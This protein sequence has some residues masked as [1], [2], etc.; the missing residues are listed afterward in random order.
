MIPCQWVL[1]Y[2]VSPAEDYDP[3]QKK[4]VSPKY[5]TKLHLVEF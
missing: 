2:N 4:K 1:E 3:H 5:N